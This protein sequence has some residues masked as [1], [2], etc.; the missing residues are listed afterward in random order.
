MTSNAQTSEQRP[1]WFVGAQYG[2]TDHTERFLRDSV[3]DASTDSNNRDK[4]LVKSMQPG[5]RIAIKAT[6]VRKDDL[7]F[8]YQGKIASCMSIKAVGTVRENLGDGLHIRV[9]WARAEPQRTW[10]FYT[11]RGTVWKV[12]SKQGTLPWA[13]DA[14]IRF[15]FHNEEQNY[16]RFLAAWGVAGWDQLVYRARQYIESG[17]VDE[18]EIKYKLEIA[19]KLAAVRKQVLSGAPITDEMARQLRSALSGANLVYFLTT[20]RFYE[21]L[22]EQREDTHPDSAPNALRA[23]WDPTWGGSNGFQMLAKHMEVPGGG[24]ASRINLISVLLMGIDPNQF[25]PYRLSAFT[26]AYDQAGYPRPKEGLSESEEYGYALG[27]LDQFIDEAAQRGFTLPN[28]LYAQ[29]ALWLMQN[30]PELVDPIFEPKPD[31]LNALAEKLYL[32]GEF[33]EEINALLEEKRQVIFQGPP[34]TGK[35]YVAQALARHLAGAKERVTLVQF[36]PSYAYEDF[37]QGYRPTLRG[38]TA[39][40]ELRD[41]PMMRAA[42]Q[43]GK[44]PKTTK[45]FLIIDEINRGNLAKVFGELYF[46]LEYRDEAMRLQYSDDEFSVPPN[47]YIIGTMNTADRSIALVDLALR[48]RFTFVRFDTGEEPVKGLLRRWLEANEP[49]MKCVADVVDGANALLNDRDAAVGP[50]YFMKKG[51]NEERARRIWKHDVLPYIEERLYGEHDRLGE[52]DFDVLRKKRPLPGG[53][54]DG[55][56]VEEQPS[57]VNNET[58]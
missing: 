14:L 7:P 3:W 18:L 2:G 11:Y 9:D 30:A 58:D 1:Y 31:D 35:T 41:G 22:M 27:F 12:E 44:D 42:E 54:Q 19:R 52:F 51:L 26:W 34:G 38:G 46:L 43:A 32:T 23:L 29:S 48:R 8:D 20:V 21:L 45:H 33:L 28:R 4:A 56:E 39:G 5:D 40:F 6:F 16:G 25:P 55:S 49:E 13:A 50:S 57:G 53:E 37:I 15:T 47:L 24:R 17:H 10:Y 36:H